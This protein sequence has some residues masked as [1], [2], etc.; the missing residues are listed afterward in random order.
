MKKFSEFNPAS[1]L[2][3]EETRREYLNEVF[4][5]GD[6]DEIKRALFLVAKS[7][8]I[9]EIADKSGLS[10]DSIYKMFRPNS[11]PRFGS[12]FKVI[13]ALNLKLGV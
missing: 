5:N 1:Y 2:D 13:K 10:R 7:R 6:E 9:A 3:S 4:A 11:K 8:G 12:V